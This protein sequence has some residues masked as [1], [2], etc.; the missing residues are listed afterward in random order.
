MRA[1]CLAVLGFALNE[2]ACEQKTCEYACA[3]LLMQGPPGGVGGSWLSLMNRLKVRYIKRGNLSV[4]WLHRY[5][6]MM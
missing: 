5:D 1:S 3:L 2:V 4:R 6:H